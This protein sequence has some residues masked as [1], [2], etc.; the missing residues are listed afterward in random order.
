MKQIKNNYL[1]QYGHTTDDSWRWRPAAGSDV[2]ALVQLSNEQI[3]HEVNDIYTIDL[4]ELGRNM[5]LSIVNQFYNPKKELFSVACDVES[6]EIIAY[7]W[8]ER[9]QYVPWSTEE[10]IVIR[11]SQVAPHISA[12]KKLFLLAQQ[13]RMWDVWATACGI[14][15]IVSATIRQKTD[16]FLRLHE[17]AGYHIKGSS[18]Y[19][20]LTTATFEVAIPVDPQTV[21]AHATVAPVVDGQQNYR[22]KQPQ[23]VVVGQASEEEFYKGQSQ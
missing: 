18:G 9:G 22:T 8:A 16:A 21:T 3:A 20:R 11:M 1:E 23:I 15:I 10:C 17:Q 7:T 6:G 13:L 12:R 2:D 4:V 5:L 19:K 14:K